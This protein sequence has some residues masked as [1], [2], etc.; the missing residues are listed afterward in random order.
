[1]LNQAKE[2]LKRKSR[3]ML[4]GK[5]DIINYKTHLR[6]LMSMKRVLMKTEDSEILNS[7]RIA[8][9]EPHGCKKRIRKLR[10]AT[11]DFSCCNRSVKA[12]RDTTIMSSERITR[13]V[14]IWSFVNLRLCSEIIFILHHNQKEGLNRSNRPPNILRLIRVQTIHPQ[15]YRFK[16]LIVVVT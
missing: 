8:Y 16:N 7:L 2:Q 6:Q 13:V 12:W 4:D 10:F 14:V 9:K 5:I 3:L 1:M 11:K 15:I